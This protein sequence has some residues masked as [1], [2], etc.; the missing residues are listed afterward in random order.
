MLPGFGL[1]TIKWLILCLSVCFGTIA[2]AWYLV[3]NSIPTDIV[4]DR[5]KLKLSRSLGHEV[6]FSGRPVFQLW[7]TP[8]IRLN[9]FQIGGQGTP[10]TENLMNAESISANFGLLSALLGE[11]VFSGLTLERPNIQFALYPDGSSNWLPAISFANGAIKYIS[12]ESNQPAQDPTLTANA[13]V[14]TDELK[15]LG[16]DQIDIIGG[17]F[18]LISNPGT[19]PERITSINGFLRWPS[20]TAPLTA[21]LNAIFRGEPVYLSLADLSLSELIAG[22]EIQSQLLM[23]SPLV[24]LSYNGDLQSGRSLFL[25]GSLQVSTPSLRRALE[26]SG[27]D[28]QAGAAL[29]NIELESEI[30]GSLDSLK[31]EDIILLVGTNRGIG[32][33]DYSINQDNPPLLSGTLAFNSLDIESFFRAFTPL[34]SSGQDIANTIDTR[35]LKELGLDLRLSAQQANFGVVEMTNLAAT[36]Q[37]N[38]QDATFNIGGA[39]AYDGQILGRVSISDKGIDGGGEISFSARQMQIQPLLEDLQINGPI[40]DGASNIDIRLSSERPLWATSVEN[41]SGE[42]SLTMD[43]GALPNIDLSQ[44]EQ[45]SNNLE[46][47]NLSEFGGDDLNFQSAKVN[48]IINSGVARLA[49][50]HIQTSDQ[51][52]SFDGVLPFTK[53]SLAL[54]ATITNIAEEQMPEGDGA[55]SQ[56]P[57]ALVPETPVSFFV[58]G[59]WP[60]PVLS[61]LF[62][63]NMLR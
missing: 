55:P 42:F 38:E 5:F 36:V 11:P 25:D 57:D 10:D 28:I 47:R 40:P 22:Q 31:L 53:G 27:R 58:G 29:G 50:T 14:T 54:I 9:G 49:D 37:I 24:N 44:I 2:L 34:P 1:K 35:F 26:W 13:A 63:S 16:F 6:Q 12:N 20:Y 7:P 32:I 51:E 62:S 30:S 59:S 61:P 18:T 8:S 46:F 21:D 60:N 15:F 3:P 48:A 4:V 52:L 41:I 45:L 33:I 39:N 19:E 43:D 17:T 23:E 56:S